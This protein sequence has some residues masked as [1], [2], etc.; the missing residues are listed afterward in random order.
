M[1]RI[2]IAMTVL[3]AFLL[4]TPA[5][6]ACG[7][8][9]G[10]ISMCPKMAAALGFTPEQQTKIDALAAKLQKKAD[11]LTKKAEA[12]KEALDKAW[13]A[14]KPNKKA[15]LKAMTAK[16]K[17]KGELAALQVEFKFGLMGI[18]TPDQKAKAKEMMAAK[19]AEGGCG[20][21]K[22]EGGCDC[23]KGEGG[24]AAAPEGA[25]PEGG[26]NCN[27]PDCPH[28]KAAGEPA[29]APAPAP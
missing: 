23:Q 10:K 15:V 7:H 9:D 4:A 24:E 14:D 3:V 16:H 5:V 21:Q 22:G 8:G 13:A 19:K 11:A 2:L 29:P 18:M 26:C 25:K 17:V 12:A 6:L 27:N 1:P 28:H 20:C